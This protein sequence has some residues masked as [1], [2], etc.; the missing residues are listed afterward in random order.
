MSGLV[1]I[2]G[3]NISSTESDVNIFLVK[4]W[5][6]INRLSIIWKSHKIKQEFFQAV[7]VWILLHGCTTWM[8]TKYIKKKLY[9]NYTRMLCTRLNK[10]W[11]QQ[12]TKQQMYG[13]LPPITQTVQVRH[14]RH[15]GYCLEEQE[16]T[17]KQHSSMYPYICS[18]QCRPTSTN[19]LTS[20]LCKH[21]VYFGGP[22]MSDGW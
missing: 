22:A 6:T 4:V 5:T 8:L 13:H 19:L 16:Q 18:H 2:P 10:S 1:H 20:A 17:N 11:K 14:T 21:W 9:G 15:V 12:P 3:Q 7:W